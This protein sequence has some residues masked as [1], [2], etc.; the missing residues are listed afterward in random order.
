MATN[1]STVERILNCIPSPNTEMD[2]TIEDAIG[3]E[4]LAAAPPIPESKDLRE[5]WWKINN[6]GGTGSC[7][8]WATADSVIRWHLVKVGRL[9][10]DQLLSPRFTWMAAKETDRFTSVPTTFIEVQ[11]TSLKAA[12]DISRNFGAVPDSVLPFKSGDL[13]GGELRT[14]YAIAARYKIASYFNLGR[15]LDKWRQWLAN[16]GPILTRLNCDTTWEN[17]KDPAT[18]GKLDVYYPNNLP[19]GHAVAMVGYLK[20]RLIIR[21]SWGEDWGD[22]GFGYAS[23]EYAG[24]AFTEAY[25]VSVT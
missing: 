17:A 24:A 11:G 5:P 12:L 15:D 10:Q 3:A 4:L 7:V 9:R 18:E 1:S 2:W 8:G 19:R 6:Q 14:F 25:G 21:N 22:K 13:Y 20:D 23:E 16:N